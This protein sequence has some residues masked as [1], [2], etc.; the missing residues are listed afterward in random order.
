MTNAKDNDLKRD[1]T[2]HGWQQM[3]SKLKPAA[4]EQLQQAVDAWLNGSMSMADA[5]A[6]VRGVVPVDPSTLPLNPRNAKVVD[7]QLYKKVAKRWIASD[8]SVLPLDEP[9]A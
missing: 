9:P 5:G 1:L 3:Q 2:E 8:G 6:A 7:G 4:K